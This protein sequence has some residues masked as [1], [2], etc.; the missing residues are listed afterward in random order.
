MSR[1]KQKLGIKF[2][3]HELKITFKKILTDDAKYLNLLVDGCNVI[4]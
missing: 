4:G 2:S 3:F 1:T